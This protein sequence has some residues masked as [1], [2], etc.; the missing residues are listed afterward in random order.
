[1]KN[2]I[3]AVLMLATFFNAFSQN[4]E[5]KGEITNN[6]LP[7]SDVLIELS[8]SNNSIKAIS[9]EK[10]IF[11]AVFGSFKINEI[12]FSAY[13]E[14]Y[15]GIKDSLIDLNLSTNLNI[16]LKKDKVTHLEEVVITSDNRTIEKSNKTIY[17]ITDKDYLKNSKAT[18]A[19][20]GLPTLSVNNDEIVIDNRKRAIIFIDGIESSYDD[21]KTLDIKEIDKV[22]V[23]SNPSAFYGDEFKGGIIKII[24]KGPKEN[25]YKG[26]IEALKGIRLGYSNFSPS[27]TYKD[28]T[29][30]F[31][32][33]YSYSTNNQNNNSELNRNFNNSNYKQTIN[34]N[35]K[36][37]QDYLSSRL[38][39][40]L[41]KTSN[42]VLSGSLSGYSF[43]GNSSGTIAENDINNDVNSSDT[44]EIKRVALNSVYNYSISDNNLL[45]VKL[46]Y[47]NLSNKTTAS[48][49][50][51]YYEVNS[52]ME[53]SSAEIVYEKNNV[54]VFTLPVEISSGYKNTF[55]KFDL[56]N[57]FNIS[58][59]ISSVYLNTDIALN[60]KFSIF[61][62]L[63][64]ANTQNKNAV[65]NQD[66]NNVLPTL[67]AL[68]KINS[69]YSLKLDYS[70]KITRPN[71]NLLN[72]DPLFINPLYI[73]IGNSTLL[74]E[75][76]NSYEIS[77]IKKMKDNNSISV[78]L[79]NE[80]YKD[81]ISEVFIENN[82]NV[83][84]TYNNIGTA[85]ISGI[86][87][88][89]TGKLFKVMDLNLNNGISYNYYKSNSEQ[90]L[91]KQ[92]NGFS[93]NSNVNL[94]AMVKERVSLSLNCSYNSHN[95]TLTQTIHFK[96]FLNFDAETN[97]FKDNLNVRLSYF[98]MFGLYAKTKSNIDYPGFS[99]NIINTNKMTN[100]NLTLTY[101]F[102]KSF[103]DRFSNPTINND[104]IK[105]K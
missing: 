27:F 31:K 104:D 38:K 14:G 64:F 55:R 73:L 36:G 37:W 54:N 51:N 39:I 1:M 41:N 103:S 86:N 71:A 57:D 26:E 85:N 93:F 46:K 58:Q 60:F 21:L 18:V 88:S 7:L 28:K 24:K 74:P 10:G 97:F 66:Y 22:E 61:A 63:L 98:D 3:L 79:F 50:E 42:I 9:D 78:K 47:F 75:L 82:T 59:Y 56:D 52:N 30:I 84:N 89:F 80:N 94:Y 101:R 23:I 16:S 68:Y 102:G 92:N 87:L 8:Y 96:P 48:Y 11:K 53:E 100:L 33:F 12:Y 44:D 91:V 69:N 70:K 25:F 90:T 43:T 29:I 81:L 20:R 105:T 19:L 6:N 15:F 4:F 62:S 5:I 76:K 65:T 99:Q 32:I 67:S 45:F 49:L 17:K 40:N 35:I 13:K 77:L 83:I 2:N 34:K 95:Y 72:P